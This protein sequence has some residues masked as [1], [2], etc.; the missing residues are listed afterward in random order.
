MSAGRVHLLVAL[1]LE[2][3][4]VGERRQGA[5][6]EGLVVAHQL[7][8]HLPGQADGAGLPLEG[9]RAAGR[10]GQQLRAAVAGGLVAREEDGRLALG[11]GWERT[12]KGR[13]EVSAR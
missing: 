10:L 13:Q 8:L 1:V 5:Q 4:G 7:A 11:A 9:G 12:S 2:L 3:P 6:V